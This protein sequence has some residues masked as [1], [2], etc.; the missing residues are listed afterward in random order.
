MSPRLDHLPTRTLATRATTTQTS[1]LAVIMVAATLVNIRLT[2]I[3]R[4]LPLAL[5]QKPPMSRRVLRLQGSK[6]PSTSNQT[7]ILITHMRP[8]QASV[9]KPIVPKANVTPS[10]IR[11]FVPSR[12]ALHVSIRTS[13]SWVPLT[14]QCR[15]GVLPGS[16]LALDISAPAYSALLACCI[17]RMWI[18]NI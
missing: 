17:T 7:L 6:T 9:T 1:T 18:S 13:P 10:S 4:A 15:Y 8:G 3:S 16:I 11:S 12:C 2:Q 5:Q 14:P